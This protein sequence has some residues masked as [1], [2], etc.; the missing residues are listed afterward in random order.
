MPT[1]PQIVATKSCVWHQN[2][3][4][5]RNRIENHSTQRQV[6]KN[7]H[8]D[9]KKKKSRE[10]YYNRKLLKFLLIS[11]FSHIFDLKKSKFPMC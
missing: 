11:S 5:N 2:V 1:I 3:F 6:Q 10:L 8:G 7:V 4:P 9:Q